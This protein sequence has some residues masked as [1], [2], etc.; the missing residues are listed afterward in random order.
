[1]SSEERGLGPGAADFKSSLGSGGS[2]LCRSFY[3]EVA[4]ISWLNG[5]GWCGREEEG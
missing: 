2:A 5:T 3:L 1:M 4:A